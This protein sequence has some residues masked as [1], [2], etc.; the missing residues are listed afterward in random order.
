MTTKK[1]ES[2]A[3]QNEIAPGG[4]P[5]DVT[6][7]ETE[8]DYFADPEG[9]ESFNGIPGQIQ[10]PDRH[11]D[12]ERAAAFAAYKE[13][14]LDPRGADD[15]AYESG[16]VNPADRHTEEKFDDDEDA[17]TQRSSRKSSQRGA[18]KST[19]SKT[20]KEKDE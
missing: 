14:H 20:S 2:T 9:D 12:A 17:G 5:G 18:Q 15:P 4:E 16:W 11:V 19:R 3:S 7:E 8:P 1:S 13:E 10:Y 6:G